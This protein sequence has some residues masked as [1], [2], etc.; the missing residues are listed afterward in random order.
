MEIARRKFSSSSPSEMLEK[1]VSYC[2]DSLK[3]RTPL[4]DETDTKRERLSPRITRPQRRSVTLFPRR[5]V[6]SLEEETVRDLFNTAMKKRENSISDINNFMR[7]MRHRTYVPSAFTGL[8]KGRYDDE[9][10]DE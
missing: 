8:G 5:T 9:Y 3:G 2:E 1:L 10:D 4:E 6:T 7:D